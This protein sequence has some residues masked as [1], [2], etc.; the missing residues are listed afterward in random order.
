MIRRCLRKYPQRV[1]EGV[2]DIG[3]LGQLADIQAELDAQTRE[4]VA[5]LR[6]EEGGAYSWTDIGRALGITRASAQQRFGP[7]CTDAARRAGGQPAHL[8]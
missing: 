5:A 1:R 7:Y 3:S 2:A 4:A 6:S 8:R